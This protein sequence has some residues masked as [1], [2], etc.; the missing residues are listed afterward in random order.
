MYMYIKDTLRRYTSYHYWLTAEAFDLSNAFRQH[1]QFFEIDQSVDLWVIAI[2]EESEVL[3]YDG[4][5]RDEGWVCAPLKLPV[6][7]HVM[8]WVHIRTQVLG[9]GGKR[10]E[11]INSLKETVKN[12]LVHNLD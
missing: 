5:E 4:E 9:G 7:G 3:L 6:F 8:E 12:I 11:V 1:P 10:W 2:K